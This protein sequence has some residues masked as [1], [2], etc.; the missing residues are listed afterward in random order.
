MGDLICPVAGP[1]GYSNDWGDPRSGHTH[2]GN[3]LF[4]SRGT[5]AVAVRG[6]SVMLQEGGGG[7]LMAFL[8]SGGDMFFY[9]HLDQFSVSDGASVSQGQQ[10]GTVGTS[11]NASADAPHLHFEIH[12]GGGGP[13]NP[14]DTISMIC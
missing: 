11:G 7:G 8:Y 14:Y 13:V 12:P 10:L 9:A 6:G 3:D 4:A 5:P 2:Q 1:V